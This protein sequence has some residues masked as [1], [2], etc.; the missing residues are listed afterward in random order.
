MAWN[1]ERYLKMKQE[2]QSDIDAG[3]KEPYQYMQLYKKK[4]KIED[5]ESAKAITEVLKP[6]NY[7]TSD[8]HRHISELK[9]K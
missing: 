8:T 4:I 2:C 1:K 3:R 5:Y 6:L 9:Q 7:D